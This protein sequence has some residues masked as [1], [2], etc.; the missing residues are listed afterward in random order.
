MEYWNTGTMG[1]LW[2][3]LKKSI[4]HEIKII[5]DPNNAPLIDG[6]NVIYTLSPTESLNRVIK[7]MRPV[8][9]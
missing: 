6:L 8:M 9:T 7:F 3:G 4:F 5:M 2:T 1:F